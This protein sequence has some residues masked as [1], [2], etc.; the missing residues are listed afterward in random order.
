MAPVKNSTGIQTQLASLPSPI[1][2]EQRERQREHEQRADDRQM[3]RS[4]A[5]TITSRINPTTFT[6]GSTRCSIP[7]DS[8]EC[9]A[10]AAYS[11]ARSR[12]ASVASIKL[13]LRRRK[14]APTSRP[15]TMISAIPIIA[16]NM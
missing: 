14:S 15:M 10:A 9:S 7:R 4:A 3:A 16:E 1:P 11:D 12:L 13:R 2:E 8:A 6:R 5:T